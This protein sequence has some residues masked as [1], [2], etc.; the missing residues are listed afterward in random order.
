MTI[1]NKKIGEIGETH[2]IQ[3]IEMLILERTDKKLLRDD[4]FYYE[5][6][7]PRRGK[8]AVPLTLCLNSD[9]LVSTTDVP[10]QMSYRQIGRKSVVMNISDLVVKGVKP[11]GIII[12]FGVPAS[13]NIAEF[14]SIVN[15]IIDV[16]LQF[17]MEYI[18]GDVNESKDV[19]INPTVFGFQER[20]LIIHR[21]GIRTGDLLVANGVF[22]LTGVGF[23]I[24]LNRTSKGENPFQKFK[25]YKTSINSVLSP[26]IGLE[27]TIVAE[28]EFAHASIDSSDGLVK[29]LEELKRSNPGLGFEIEQNES[30]IH[31]EALRYSKEFDVPVEKLIFSGGG[32][33]YIHLFV[34]TEESYQKAQELFKSQKGALHR[35]GRVINEEGIYGVQK[36]KRIKLEG[37]GYE[38][39]SSDLDS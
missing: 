12:S 17:E 34:M 36:S 7:K 24:L 8:N 28:K 6:I 1:D 11:Q 31:E 21:S 29:S 20:N 9:M 19:I 32:E 3:L 18:G 35:I 23:D 5:V 38:H 25:K 4:S 26:Q 15:G 30:L 2:V 37:M 10:E 27:G 39:F 16:C 14:K 22:G 13:L 33:E